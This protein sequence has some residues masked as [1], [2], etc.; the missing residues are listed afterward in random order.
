MM[1]DHDQELDEGET[2]L[3]HH[4][5]RRSLC[6]SDAF[7]L[8]CL[9]FTIGPLPCHGSLPNDAP[10]AGLSFSTTGEATPAC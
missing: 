6:H 1:N 10:S 4:E 9:A 8:L 3:V 2:V 5:P 7:R